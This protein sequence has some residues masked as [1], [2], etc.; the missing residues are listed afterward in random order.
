[1]FA[2]S[3][4][5][6][7]WAA[8]EVRKRLALT[9]LVV[10]VYRL[11]LHIPTPGVNAHPAGIAVNAETS[12]GIGGAVLLLDVLTGGAVSTFSVLAVGLYAFVAAQLVIYLLVAFVPALSRRMEADPARGQALVQRWTSVLATLL[13]LA[14]SFGLLGLWS[15]RLAV[16]LGGLRVTGPLGSPAP[17]WLDTLATVA[18]LMAGAKFAEWLAQVISKHGLP[19]LGTPALVCAGLLAALPLQIYHLWTDLPYGW[20][21]LAAFALVTAAS[22][23]IVVYLLGGRR[24]VPIL[25][26]R[27]Q[28]A[29]GEREGP[30]QFVPMPVNPGGVAPLIAAQALLALPVFLAQPLACAGQPGRI[31]A[32][33]LVDFAAPSN[34]WLWLANFLLVVALTF[35]FAETRYYEHKLDEK[36]QR[37][38]AVVPG[39]RPGESTRRYLLGVQRR[40]ALPG[41]LLLACVA[42]SPYLVNCALGANLFLLP[43]LGLLI[44]VGTIRDAKYALEAEALSRGHGL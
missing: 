9:L 39:V 29:R 16:C 40:I 38:G 24:E 5:A 2:R 35:L 8:P 36:M 12:E 22:I 4:R 25:F 37:T 41:A 26:P 1:M 6:S 15:T 27:R 17:D 31:V 14:M 43:A 34:P 42:I 30:R 13:G 10:V 23:V 18:A 19:G 33:A 32:V 7:V 21:D 3:R 11:V 44:L 20:I 28:A